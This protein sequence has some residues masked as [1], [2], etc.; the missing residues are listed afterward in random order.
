[1]N[2]IY[3]QGGFSLLELMVTLLIIAVLTAAAIPY[4]QNAVQSA[5]NTEAIIW[6]GH[7][8]RWSTGAHFTQESA[9]RLQNRANKDTAFKYFTVSIVCREREE[10]DNTPCW[11]AELHL[12]NPSQHIQYYLATTHNFSQLVCVPLNNAGDSFCQGQAGHEEADTQVN[13]LPAY[14]IRF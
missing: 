11:E 2:K 5:R 10:E 8:K 9:E 1:M 4:Y 7:A 13:N 14:T 3:N 6:W 12:Q